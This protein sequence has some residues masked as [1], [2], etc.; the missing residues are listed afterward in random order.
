MSKPKKKEAKVI[1][2]HGPVDPPKG[3]KHTGSISKRGIDGPDTYRTLQEYT[4]DTLKNEGNNV[5]K[6]GKK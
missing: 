5:G 3:Y 4:E 1:Y 2:R 6:K